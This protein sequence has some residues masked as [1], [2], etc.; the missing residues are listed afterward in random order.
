M[1]LALVL[2][3]PQ[4]GVAIR[5]AKA[6]VGGTILSKFVFALTDYYPMQTREKSTV[7]GRFPR[8]LGS[9]GTRE[10]CQSH[11]TEKKTGA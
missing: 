9:L 7:D 6:G 11:P 2:T 5:A 3:E 4:P 10:P 8:Q 1:Q